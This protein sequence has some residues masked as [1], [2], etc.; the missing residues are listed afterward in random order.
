VS[1]L[2]RI[3]A[4]DQGGSG[5]VS[6]QTHW[7]ARAVLVERRRRRAAAFGAAGELRAALLEWSVRPYLGQRQPVDGARRATP[8]GR[9]RGAGRDR[10]AVS[11]LRLCMGAGW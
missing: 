8:P 3:V 9:S 5:R 7:S 2:P 6:G 1:R 4:D 10:G 11:R